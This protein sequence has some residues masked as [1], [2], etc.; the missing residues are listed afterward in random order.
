MS[1]EKIAGYTAQSQKKLAQVN[2][3]KMLEE[4][5]LRE[6]ETLEGTGCDGPCDPRWLRI[7][8]THMQEGFMALNRSIMNPK[9]LTDE[10]VAAIRDARV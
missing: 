1:T 3:H 9:R 6:I 5:I 8:A 2:F 7:A 4:R 10:E